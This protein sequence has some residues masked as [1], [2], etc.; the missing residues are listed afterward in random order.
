MAFAF[1]IKIDG[2][3]KPPIWRKV[4]V[5]ESMTFDDFHLVIQILFGW[6]DSHLFEFTPKGWSSNPRITLSFDEKYE[7]DERFSERNTFPYGE[8]YRADEIRLSDYFKEVKQ[9][10]I[11]IYDFSDDWRH[12]VELADITDDAVLLPVC[13]AGKG[14]HL[15]EDCGGIGSFYNMV[16]AVNNPK[17]P[18]HNEYREWL[19]MKR[20]EKWDLNFFDLEETNEVLREIWTSVEKQRNSGFILSDF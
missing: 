7:P 10:I 17:H 8:L 2:S 15:E 16:E 13:L 4:K 5:N 14:S 6:A 11:Y 1:K 20:G 19:G 3:A 9:K 12:I 18:E